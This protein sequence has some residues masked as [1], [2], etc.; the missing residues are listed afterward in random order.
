MD[1]PEPATFAATANVPPGAFAPPPGQRPKRR[2]RNYILDAGLQ[3]RYVVVVTLISAAIAGTLGFL[4]H[5]LAE[6][7]TLAIERQ[8]ATVD[9]LDESAREIILAPLRQED[10]SRAALMVLVAFG[11]VGVLSG[12]LVVM[13]HRVA[14]PLHKIAGA[15]DVV[16]DGRLPPLQALRK[17]D[18]FQ[19]FF[20]QFRAMED[21][22]RDRARAE[23][24]LLDAV[25]DAGRLAGVGEESIAAEPWTDLGALAREKRA[26]FE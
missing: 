6:H 15:F 10:R 25:V 13:T 11:L 17:G 4:E 7:A 20:E 14:G 19:A 24:E 18:H 5:R 8:L 23:A 9:F 21:A 2:F 26:A 12:Y 16:R 1:S 22:L 3:L